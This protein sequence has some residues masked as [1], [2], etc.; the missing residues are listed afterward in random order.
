MPVAHVVTFTFTPAATAETIDA[1]AHAL[2]TVSRACTGIDSY[3]HG[4]DLRL[5]EGTADYAVTAVFVDRD[6]LQAYLADPGHQRLTTDFA[7]FIA[8]KSSVQFRT[9]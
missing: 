7:P 6:A 2:D 9:D 5:R 8:A 1:L 3:R 4:A